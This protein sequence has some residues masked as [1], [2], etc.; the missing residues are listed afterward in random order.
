MTGYLTPLSHCNT[1]QGILCQLTVPNQ[2]IR[3]LYRKIIEQWLSNG[4]GAPWYNAFM[5]HLLEGNVAAFEHDLQHILEQTISYHDT[6]QQPES[7]YHGFMLGITASLYNR[8]HYETKSN[9]ESGHGRYDYMILSRDLK[10]L[11]IILEFKTV[12]KNATPSDMRKAAKTALIQIT[13]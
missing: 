5:N 11:T 1:H 12:K 7:F 4:S 13:P 2:E 8:P 6:A 10:K 9:R 3:N